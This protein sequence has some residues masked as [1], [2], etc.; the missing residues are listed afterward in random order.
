ML[1]LM[2]ARVGTHYIVSEEFVGL[3]VLMYLMLFVIAMM[4]VIVSFIASWKLFE[5]WVM[6][7]GEVLFHFT[8]HMF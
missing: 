8:Q 1:N 2:A 3:V 5:K 7:D 4:T 6:K